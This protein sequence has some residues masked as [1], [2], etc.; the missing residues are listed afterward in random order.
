MTE[1]MRNGDVTAVRRRG[2]RDGLLPGDVLADDSGGCTNPKGCPQ[3]G[4]AMPEAPLE[5]GGLEGTDLKDFPAPAPLADA[6][7]A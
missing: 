5:P 3:P 4:V 7:L 6:A 1:S 2:D